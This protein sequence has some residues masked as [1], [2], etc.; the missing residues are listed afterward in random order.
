MLGGDLM[1]AGQLMIDL[2]GNVMLLTGDDVHKRFIVEFAEKI[3]T[4][5]KNLS[6]NSTNRRL[7][8]QS[9]FNNDYSNTLI[10]EYMTVPIRTSLEIAYQLALF[11]NLYSLVFIFLIIV[12][13]F[14]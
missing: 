13:F 10:S 2:L 6:T 7:I 12:A 5:D 8:I 9:Q 1:Y 14:F 4:I 3:Q 11:W